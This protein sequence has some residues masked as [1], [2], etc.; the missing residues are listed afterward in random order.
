MLT[1]GWKSTEVFAEARVG[2]RDRCLGNQSNEW[3]ERYLVLPFRASVATFQ[4][5]AGLRES[6]LNRFRGALQRGR[7]GDTP[8][9]YSSIGATG[10]RDLV[11]GLVGGVNAEEGHRAWRASPAGETGPTP[12]R[13]A[14]G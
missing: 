14:G 11:R 7:I 3:D 8:S 9:V 4:L 10:W 2:P 12:C 5:I 1:G 6:L 13:N